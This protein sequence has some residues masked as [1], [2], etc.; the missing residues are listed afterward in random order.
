LRKHFTTDNLPKG[1]YNSPPTCKQVGVLVWVAGF[2][3]DL[4]SRTKSRREPCISSNDA[5]PYGD[6]MH[7]LCKYDV[8]PVGR[9]DAMF[10]PKCGEATHH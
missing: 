6:M 7:L 2:S 10:A 3:K 5:S 1:E 8:A 9:S 4:N